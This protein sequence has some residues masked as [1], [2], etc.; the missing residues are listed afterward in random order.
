MVQN[1]R[2]TVAVERNSCMSCFDEFSIKR[3]DKLV[4]IEAGRKNI[5]QQATDKKLAIIK[6]DCRFFG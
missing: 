1:F 5:L 6:A 3:F 4:S 2:A